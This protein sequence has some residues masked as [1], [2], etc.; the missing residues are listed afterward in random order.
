MAKPVGDSL[1]QR[2]AQETEYGR[3]HVR[4]VH[5][6]TDRYP[7]AVARF[8]H[9]REKRLFQSDV[10]LRAGKKVNAFAQFFQRMFRLQIRRND[11]IF[12][13]AGFLSIT[14]FAA[15]VCMITVV[16]E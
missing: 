11:T 4:V 2:I 10:F 15:S 12:A 1:F 13:S 7:R 14:S 8:A 6:K 9:D 3:R 5:V 16:I